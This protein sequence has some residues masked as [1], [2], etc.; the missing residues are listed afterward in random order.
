MSRDEIFVLNDDEMCSLMN[1]DDSDWHAF[2]R[3]ELMAVNLERSNL[4]MTSL[5]SLLK[6]QGQ[7]IQILNLSECLNLA[8]DSLAEG[9]HLPNLCAL[10]LK[11]SDD[12][13]LIP[14]IASHA[15]RTISLTPAAINQLISSTET[16]KHLDL[17]YCKQTTLILLNTSI[18]RA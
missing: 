6:K 3:N 10:I 5:N 9:L 18:M 8:S 15:R 12:D 16:L 17:S 1:G 14:A 7:W 11:S 2:N 13:T 4:S